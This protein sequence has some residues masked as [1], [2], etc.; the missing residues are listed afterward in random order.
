MGS[1]WFSKVLGCFRRWKVSIIGRFSK[2]CWLSSPVRQMLL[3]IDDER[4]LFLKAPMHSQ[5]QVYPL[6]G[7]GRLN[8]GINRHLSSMELKIPASVECLIK[9]RLAKRLSNIICDNLSSMIDCCSPEFC[10]KINVLDKTRIHAKA[11]NFGCLI[12]RNEYCEVS[13]NLV[14][15][16]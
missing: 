3:S 15:A 5:W 7:N 12:V 4:R 1:A 14:P 9:L 11:K 8:G 6:R 13:L 16:Q 10:L 2:E